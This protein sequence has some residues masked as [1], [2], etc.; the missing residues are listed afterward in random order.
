MNRP[1]VRLGFE[2]AIGAIF[3]VLAVAILV[4]LTRR[5]GAMG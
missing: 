3:L 2:R 5:G 1:A 4:D